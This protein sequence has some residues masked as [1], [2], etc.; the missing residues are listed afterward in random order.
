MTQAGQA[1]DR[2]I[3]LQP[4]LVL[5]DIEM[6]ELSGFEV[7]QQ[8]KTNPLTSDVSVIFI[9]AHAESEFEFSSLAFGAIDFIARPFNRAICRLRVQNHL[10]LQ[11]QSKALLLSKQQLHAEKQRL[12]VT[13]NAIGDAV[14]A[15]DTEGVITMMNPIAEQMTG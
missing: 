1:L 3:E 6:P 13:L 8:L 14:I 2:A 15:T 10:T 5:L 11:Q 9:S 12:H 7:C 4:D